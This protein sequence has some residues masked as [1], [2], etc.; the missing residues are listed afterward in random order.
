MILCN[1]HGCTLTGKA[2]PTEDYAK[3]KSAGSMI[4][5]VVGAGIIFGVMAIGGVTYYLIACE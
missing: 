4:G 3:A 1:T 5:G 2:A